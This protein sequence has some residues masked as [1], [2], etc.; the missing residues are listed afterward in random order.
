MPLIPQQQLTEE[1]RKKGMKITLWEGLATEVMNTITGSSLAGSTFLVAMAILL[2]A[3]NFQIGFLAA[4]PTLTNIFQLVSIWLVRKYNNRRAVSVIFSIL[5]RIPLLSIGI[6]IVLTGTMN[7]LLLVSLLF[8]YYLCGS[9]AG[10]SWNSWM[11]DLVPENIL[12]SFFAKRSGNNQM[13]NAGLGLMLA[14]ALDF[15]RRKFPGTELNTYGIMYTIAGI[16]GLFGVIL[17]SKVPEPQSVLARE[18]IFKL[19]KRPLKDGNFKRLMVFNSLWVFAM[20]I[21][22]PFFTVFLMK[23]MGLS[24]SYVLGL[25]IISQL[26]GIITIRLWGKFADRYSNKTIIAINAPLYIIVLIAWCFVGIYSQ[27]YANLILLV[28][29]HII[30]GVA[31]GGINLSLTN[32]G[33]K[34]A[35]ANFSIV[36]L[37]VKNIITSFFSALGPLVGGILADYFEKRSLSI[38]AQWIGP[39][40]NKVLHVVSLHEWNFLFLIGAFVAFIALEFLVAVKETGEVEKD[41]VM[42]VMRS[43]IKNSLKEKYILGQLI[44]L[45]DHIWGKIRRNEH[46]EKA[47]LP[48]NSSGKS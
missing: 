25:T 46:H 17:L 8:V 47:S 12:A 26:S 21:A 43:S 4:L 38:N 23:S 39:K 41:V 29:I 2:K 14:L 31:T 32:I 18:N 22:M 36:Y 35:P 28:I 20:N 5:A 33:L 7:I 19:F 27:L 1:E 3:T 44:T 10:P 30:T 48:K 34:L 15:T 11:K 13:L 42:K 24:I 16:V 9:I 40:F 6:V 37:S 45:H